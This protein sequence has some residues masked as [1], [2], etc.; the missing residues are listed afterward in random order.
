[1]NTHKNAECVCLCVHVCL[2]AYTFS[3]KSEYTKCLLD[4]QALRAEQCS[5][6][7]K[8]A[9]PLFQN[10]IVS[11]V[12]KHLWTLHLINQLSV[13]QYGEG[14]RDVVDNDPYQ[15]LTH[16]HP[17]TE[18]IPSFF[19]GCMSKQQPCKYQIVCHHSLCLL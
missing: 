13:S 5:L 16:P 7:N 19:R 10:I 6:Y 4:V 15:N 12:E 9:P 18:I 8:T 1:M 14:D 2:H 3:F 11:S 17:T